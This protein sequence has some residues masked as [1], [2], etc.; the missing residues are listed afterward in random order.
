MSPSVDL[1]LALGL[2]A[3]ALLSVVMYVARSLRFGRRAHARA[4]ADGGSPIMSKRVVEY[5]YWLFDPLAEGL[6]RAGVTA[7][8]V[9]AF[10][11]IPG[12]AAAIAAAN[13]WFGL[14][15]VLATMSAFCDA[16]DGLIA[17]KQQVASDSGEALDATIDRYIEFF[18]QAGLL[19][20]YRDSL[21]AT[22]LCLAAILASFMVSFISAIADAKSL[23]IPRG[24]MRR[25]E[26]ALY[27]FIGTGVTPV[28]A[29]LVGPSRNL[30]VRE[31]P[32]LLA[33]LMVAVL[34]NLS[35]AIRHRALVSAAAKT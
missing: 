32:L 3:I 5:A 14:S 28:W 8:G 9:T 19:F 1:G 7:N 11:L 21:P 2:L 10:S 31:A 34:G 15:V 22:L 26:R 24:T 30:W 4:D 35:A 17:R 13:G 33:L 23:V 27:L 6:H 12:L 29:A 18:M 16:I 20:H 25:A